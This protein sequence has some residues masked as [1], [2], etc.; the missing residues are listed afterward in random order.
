[1]H[2]PPTHR[3]DPMRNAVCEPFMDIFIYLDDDDDE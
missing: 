1:M 2:Q 3:R